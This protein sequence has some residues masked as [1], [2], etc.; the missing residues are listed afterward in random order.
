LSLYVILG[1]GGQERTNEH[2]RD[3]AGAINEIGPNFIRLRTFVP[4]VNTPLLQE[5][6]EEQFKMLSPHGVLRETAALL[7][8]LTVSSMLT[9]DHYTNYVNLCGRLPDE[10]P[11]LLEEINEALTRDESEFRPFFIGTQ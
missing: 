11:R 1:I 10:K 5:V 7:E 6:M 9:S 3:T 2:A 8:G 4:K